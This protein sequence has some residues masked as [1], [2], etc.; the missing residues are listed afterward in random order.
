MFVKEIANNVWHVAPVPP[1]HLDH[2]CP[3]P[4]EIPYRLIQLYSYPG[5]TVLDP[6][7]GSGQT[8]KVAL[9]LGRNAVGFDIVERYVRYAYNR[10]RE[11]LAVRQQQLVAEFVRVPLDAPLGSLR[12]TRNASVTRHGSG[13]AARNGKRQARDA[14]G[15]GVQMRAF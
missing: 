5:N 1:G 11:P 7:L 8:T 15:V 10:L 9:A 2:P 14:A 13:L 4:D 6:F 12:R 3:F